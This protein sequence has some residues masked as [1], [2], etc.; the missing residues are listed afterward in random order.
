M[1]NIWMFVIGFIIF[2]GYMVGLL[3]AIIWGHNSQ[4]DEMLNDP[5][6]KKYYDDVLNSSNGVDMDGIGNQGRFNYR[7]K[8]KAKK[9]KQGSQ[10]RKKNYFWHENNK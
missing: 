5:E 10:S 8:P 1:M 7:P 9:R 2:G 4:R 6:L 3:S